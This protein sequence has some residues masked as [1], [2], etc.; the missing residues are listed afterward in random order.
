MAAIKQKK[1]SEIKQDEEFVKKGI[2]L[3]IE[4]NGDIVGVVGIS[5]EVME[6]R[7]FGNLLKSAVILLIE[8]SVASEKEN[9]EKT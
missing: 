4:L 8:Q 1:I 6:T 9:L 5:G 7:P 2:N 3:P